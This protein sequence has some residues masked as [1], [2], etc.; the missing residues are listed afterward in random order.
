VVT[1]VVDIFLENL[2][3]REGRE[4]HVDPLG[5]L[6][7]GYGV[8]P[9]KGTATID[10]IKGAT[11]T[12]SKTNKVLALADYDGDEQDFARAVAAEYYLAGEEIFNNRHSDIEFNNYSLEAR[13]AALDLF[14]NAGPGSARWNDVRTFLDG[15]EELN[16]GKYTEETQAKLIEFVN[17]F[18]GTSSTGSVYLPGLLR[19]R[20]TSY[21]SIAPVE[22]RAHTI[23]TELTPDQTRTRFTVYSQKGKELFTRTKPTTST[24]IGTMYVENGQWVYDALV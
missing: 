24:Q 20:L 21:N 14:Y 12:V 22:D 19:R 10:N 13:A 4:T 15:A 7:L 18:R 1:D 8:V 23:Q 3:E 17:N 2:G 11:H 9:D 5:Y 16:K 6:T